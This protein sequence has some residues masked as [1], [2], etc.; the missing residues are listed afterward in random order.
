MLLER[1]TT[2]PFVPALAFRLT[3]PVVED[4]P[5]TVDGLTLNKAK[6]TGEMV[7]VAVWLCPFKLA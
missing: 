5:L 4:P 6:V 1:L 7:S 3:V 2:N